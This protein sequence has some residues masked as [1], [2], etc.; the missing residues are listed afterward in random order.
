MV[1][2]CMV[3]RIKQDFDEQEADKP[4]PVKCNW[5]WFWTWS[6]L[7]LSS[8]KYTPLPNNAPALHSTPFIANTLPRF[9]AS[10][11]SF[12]ISIFRLLAKYS[13]RSTRESTNHPGHDNA[14]GG[15]QSEGNSCAL[16]A[17]PTTRVEIEKT[18]PSR[19]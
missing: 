2:Q 13:H 5:C 15:L 17:D 11:H 8:P 7:P 9:S 16:I 1:K 4:K 14:V 19:K 6:I 12:D 18:L 10:T 3:K